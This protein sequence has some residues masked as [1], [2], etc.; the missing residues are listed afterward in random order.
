MKANLRR[1]AISNRLHY[2]SFFVIKLN[3]WRPLLLIKTMDIPTN[4]VWCVLVMLREDY[5]CGAVAVAQSLRNVKTKYPIWCMVGCEDNYCEDNSCEDTSRNKISEECVDFL[6]A[7]F[8]HVVKVPLI[9]HKVVPMK[10]KKQN[11]IYGSWIHSSFTKWNIMNPEFFPV[12]KVILID[13]DM[14]FLENCDALFNLPA[15]AATFSS[16][17][18]Y[19]YMKKGQFK[20]AY[21]PYGEMKH[22]QVVPT[23]QIVR[24]F[25]NSIL[26]LAC[27]VLVKPSAKSYKLMLTTLN[28]NPAYGTSNCI[29]G[30]DEQLLAETWLGM[31][32]PI[33]H[34]HQ[35]YNWI[36]GKNNWLLHG[37]K[38]KSMQFYNEKPW[39]RVGTPEDRKKEVDECE[40]DDIRDFWRVADQVMEENPKALRWYYSKMKLA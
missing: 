34:I 40:W 15:P 26:G 3:I 27:M 13:A 14:L 4:N 28:H 39:V 22:G 19:P 10:S 16:P 24:G 21:N 5:A 8:D 12:D 33:H 6:R 2:Y 23:N 30:F 38:P 9:T 25:K 7:Q 35:Q 11:E 20:G 17:W 32:E 29:S 1:Y 37:E 31:N 36:V 18:A